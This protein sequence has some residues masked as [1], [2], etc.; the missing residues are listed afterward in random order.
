MKI[1]LFI[2]LTLSFKLCYNQSEIKIKSQYWLKVNLNS[3]TF[4]NGDHIKE[5]KSKEEW[6]KAL[7]DS[8]PAWCYYNFNSIYSNYYG[9]IY[10]CFVVFDKRLIVP[11]GYR[12]PSIKDFNELI[13]NCGGSK[14]A[15]KKLKSKTFYI[16]TIENMIKTQK[17]EIN[18]NKFDPPPPPLSDLERKLYDDQK[19]KE[20]ITGWYTRKKVINKFSNGFNA[21]PG[22][23]LGTSDRFFNGVGSYCHFWTKEGGCFSLY[24]S[25]ETADVN[26]ARD[27]NGNNLDVN[28]GFYIR[29]IKE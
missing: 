16:D 15:G 4:Q 27:Y 28:F 14:V 20:V 7:N 18:I 9:K 22:G 25:N 1:Y 26:I 2:L 13:K 21:M 10:N 23:Y 29:V 3:D 12:I 5:V 24:N 19:L 17:T 6:L 8:I 11:K